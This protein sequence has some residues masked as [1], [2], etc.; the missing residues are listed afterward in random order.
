MS[1]DTIADFA[2]A[3]LWQAALVH[4]HALCD[5]RLTLAAAA[6][7]RHA[8]AETDGAIAVIRFYGL[9]VLHPLHDE[10][11]VLLDG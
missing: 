11:C 6:M 9:S 5:P 7:I 3:S 4:A 8:V 1:A 10:P 2:H